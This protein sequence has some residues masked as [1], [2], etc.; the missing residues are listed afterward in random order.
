MNLLVCI[1]GEIGNKKTIFFGGS[2]LHSDRII[3]V[4]LKGHT[5]C[6]G[7]LG[8]HAFPEQ[9]LM[10]MVLH[11]VYCKPSPYRLEL[12]NTRLNRFICI[13]TYCNSGQ[14]C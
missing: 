9:R 7:H 12:G 11:T 6:G 13:S 2:L 1:I 4:S 14:L 8:L 3:G 5:K 10:R